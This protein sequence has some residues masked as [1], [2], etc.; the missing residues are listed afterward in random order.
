MEVVDDDDLVTGRN[1]GLQI[2]SGQSYFRRARRDGWT[3]PGNNDHLAYWLGHT[4]PIV[5]VL[6]APNK[7]AYWQV[8]N[9][10][11]VT[12]N[13]NGFTLFIPKSQPFDA[14][15]K[16]RLL[17]IAG[18]DSSVL[19]ALPRRYE[20]LPPDA[21][22]VLRRAADLDRL[23]AARLADRLAGGN[24]TSKMTVAS[25]LAAEP[26]WLARS[27]AAEDLWMTIGAYAAA[28]DHQR[29]SA[30][31][32]QR[33][34][35]V[36]GPRSAAACAFA[37]LMLLYDGDRDQSPA[38]LRQARDGGAILLAD[39]G[40]TALSLPANDARAFEIPP[41]IRDATAA[42]IDAEPTVL[43]FLS[44]GAIRRGD[45][46]KG[47]EYQERALARND[48]GMSGTGLALAQAIFR[49]ESASTH[50]SAREHRR[51]IAHAQAAVEERRRWHGPS[52]EALAWLLRFYITT[53]E[54]KEA[55]T[56][57]LPASLGGTAREYEAADPEVARLGALAA[58]LA[59][60]ATALT[61]FLD[62]L[63]E[64]AQTRLV[65]AQIS[66]TD[67]MSRQELVAIWTRLVEEA[68]D[69]EMAA[70]C[71]S[72]LA[73]L[74]AWPP[75]AD[76]LNR[77][78]IMQPADIAVLKAV[79][80][81]RSGNRESGLAELRYLARQN[82]SAA[83]ALVLILEEDVSP[84]AAIDESERQ[85]AVSQDPRLRLQLV[86]LL[87][88]HGHAVR[89]AQ[90]AERT[91]R[92]TSLAAFLRLEL[93]R[94]YIAEK[95]RVN[96][97][98]AAVKLA[99]E[100]LE[101]ADDPQFA[102]VVVS[103][104]LELGQPAEAR[105]ALARYR[106]QPVSDQEV[107]LWV[108]LHLG[109]PLTEDDAQ[110]VLELVDR[111]PGGQVRQGLIW[112]LVRY[113]QLAAQQGIAV[114]SRP[115]V[116][117]VEALS[118]EL[119]AG[120]EHAI[121]RVRLDDDEAIRKFLTRRQPDPAV[122][123]RLAEG[124]SDG[125]AGLWELAQE[126]NQPYGAVLLQRPVGVLFASDL[127]QGL[128][129]AGESAARSA[130]DIGR[131]V[132]DMSSL[133]LLNLIDHE[134][135]LALRSAIRDLFIPATMAND[136][137]RTRDAIHNTAVASQH[138]SLGADGQIERTSMSAVQ[139][140]WLRE[141]AG[142]LE[143]AIR[144]LHPQAVSQPGGPLADAIAL[145]ADLK[146]AIWC[147]DA[148]GRQRARGRGVP[149]FSLLDVLTVLIDRNERTESS[150]VLRRLACQYV[151]DLPLDG[152]DAAAVA[153][154]THWRIGPVHALLSRPGWWRHHGQAWPQAWYLVARAARRH[155]DAAL[156]S[157]TKAALTGALQ[158]ATPGLRT[159]RYQELVVIA[160]R[161]CHAVGQSAPQGL[162][163]DLA[164]LVG[165]NCAVAPAS[166]LRAL[167]SD[168]NQ[169]SVADA[170]T[171]AQRLLPGVPLS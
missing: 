32:F 120:D 31:A 167:V 68:T 60:D 43:N 154:D 159:Q 95:Q 131:A 8:V 127:T 30:D 29:E 22:R 46:N 56:A 111:Q 168:L 148:Y 139:R 152:S 21:V 45:L 87:R 170:V 83:H 138:L 117:R 116:E 115:L 103:G 162:L 54:V 110:T 86:G 143:D 18:R 4:L 15:T 100:G 14:S 35:E 136:A 101:I 169:Q 40:L 144:G 93:C 38:L 37:G 55:L 129:R 66:D 126:T 19:G 99:R 25:L 78:S 157:M 10:D 82:P 140:G 89:A 48:A 44:E 118:L 135:R 16:D 133:H 130:L 91:I 24:A 166:V 71:V 153:E 5:V 105:E 108:H 171:V 123:N 7:K 134:D 94:W 65:R 28:H 23:A 13:P 64:D 20:Q 12:E 75:Q 104:L 128:R 26:T 47:V 122:L 81:A 61:F 97:I 160:L 50:P 63:P 165:Q 76:D 114:F 36:G 85:V 69:D 3:F 150:R 51:A 2:K 142:L 113:V 73:F 155:S 109:Q 9:T 52:P 145:A 141:Q 1:I 70:K 161:A 41:S 98:A 107:H 11:T 80:L 27:P 146:I 59:C 102:W 156:A 42:E 137:I 6:V 158:A 106:P 147:D 33:A 151:V 74:G 84:S 67:S 17:Q 96:D 72:R 49:R 125:T 119:Q 34:A 77:R 121:W 90:V 39:I 58:H 164:E 149:A 92:D 53:G 62:A 79:Y 88:N 57:A 112:L 132:I 124:V 163:P